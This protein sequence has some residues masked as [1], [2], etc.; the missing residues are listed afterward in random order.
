MRSR[1]KNLSGKTLIVKKAYQR[2]EY[3]EAGIN[4]QL[5]WIVL[6]VFDARDSAVHL[7][8]PISM[9]EK[10]RPGAKNPSLT[11]SFAPGFIARWV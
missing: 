6:A 10:E 11:F 5:S 1:N 4:G 3:T 7:F 8:N 9:A 2:G